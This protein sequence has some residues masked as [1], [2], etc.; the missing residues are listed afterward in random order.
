MTNM[1]INAKPI[2]QGK[3]RD[4]YEISPELLLLMATDRI[5]THN[6]VHQNKVPDKGRVLTA[7]TV[8]WLTEVFPQ[9]GILPEQYHLV[10]HGS[11]ILEYLPD[12]FTDNPGE[13]IQRSL[14]VK[15]LQ[16]YPIEF[17][18]RA[19]LT[20]SLYKE[21]YSKGLP[22][23]YELQS[24]HCQSSLLQISRRLTSRWIHLM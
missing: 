14:V 9:I 19:Y 7:L 2:H 1:T 5:S 21:Y 8:F 10:A 22:N 20:G 6:I 17:I 16:M 3:V 18:Y 4:T 12:N 15:K 13:L 11:A 23:P 24:L